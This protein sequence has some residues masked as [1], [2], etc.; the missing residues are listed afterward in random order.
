MD[1]R[2]IAVLAGAAEAIHASIESHNRSREMHRRQAKR[3]HATLDE[4]KAEAKRL[5][6]SIEI[7]QTG[8]SK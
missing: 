2:T 4:I 6:I 5:G 7:T 3:L 1:H 8:R